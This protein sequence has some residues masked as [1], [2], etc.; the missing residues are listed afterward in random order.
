MPKLTFSSAGSDPNALTYAGA[1]VTATSYSKNNQV[2]HD[3]DLFI[4][5]ESH[6][7][8][9][10]NEPGTG[11]SW[12]DYWARSVDMLTAGQIAAAAGTGTPGSGNKYVTADTLGSHTGLTGSNAHGLGTI[13]TQ[14][15][16]SVSIT[17]GAISGTA[18]V[19]PEVVKTETGSLSAAECSN[20][21][22][23]NYGQGAAMTLT[24]PTAA[25]GLSFVFTVITTG[26]AAHIKAGASDKIYWSGVIMDDGDKLSLAT[27]VAGNCVSL[28]SF[29]TGASS[30]DWQAVDISGTWSDGGA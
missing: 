16:S 10:G 14:T 13:A 28:F 27:P 7:S 24:L 2:G 5:I 29:K 19:N 25:A 6:T 22:I 15:A 20:T 21:L 1:W 17:G 18:I 30:Y 3:G 8:A 26:N 11:A 9:A 12:T 23:S 4:C